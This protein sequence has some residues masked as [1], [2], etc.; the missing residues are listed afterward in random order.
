MSVQFAGGAVYCPL[1]L[2]VYTSKDTI[3]LKINNKKRLTVDV[4]KI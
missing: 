4:C 2:L 1:K 3:N